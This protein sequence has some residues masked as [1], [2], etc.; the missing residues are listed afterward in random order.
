MLCK[1]CG[2]LYQCNKKIRDLESQKTKCSNK[3]DS[4]ELLTYFNNTSEKI[5]VI[6]KWIKGMD[7]EYF[8]VTCDERYDYRGVI[9]EIKFYGYILNSDYNIPDRVIYM[10]S[11]PIYKVDF[12][13]KERYFDC[14]KIVDFVATCPNC[15]FGSKIMELFLNYVKGHNIRKVVGELSF[16]DEINEDNKLRRNHFYNKFNFEFVDDKIELD[17]EEVNAPECN[18]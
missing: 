3:V 18:N 15:G 6:E 9:N 8:V 4:L 14:I 13:S 12:I 1:N 10:I 17:F 11:E 5:L 16:V 7:D 2:H